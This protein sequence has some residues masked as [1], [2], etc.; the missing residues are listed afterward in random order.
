[1]QVA[2]RLLGVFEKLQELG[3]PELSQRHFKYAL[4]CS[5]LLPAIKQRVEY[6][7]GE[8][9]KWMEKVENIH[10]SNK[11]LLFFRVPKLIVLYEALTAENPS[12]SA[13]IQEIGFLFQR[14]AH[15]SEDFKSAVNVS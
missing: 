6:W 11:W 7:T 15:T 12:V 3:Y 9:G 5:D 8:E 13:I 14:N 2:Y 1:M 4:D 10:N